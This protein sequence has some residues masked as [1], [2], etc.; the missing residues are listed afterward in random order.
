MTM[1]TI[2]VTR[3]LRDRLK[4][5]AAAA[6]R[7]LGEQLE[8]LIEENSRAADWEA[9]RRAMAQMTPEDWADYHDEMAWWDRAAGV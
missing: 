4:E 2:K 5:Q 9:V 3:E 7:T 6:H 1:T 8:Y